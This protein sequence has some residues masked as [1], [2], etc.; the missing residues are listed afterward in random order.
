MSKRDPNAILPSSETSYGLLKG[1]IPLKKLRIEQ[2]DQSPRKQTTAVAAAV[3]PSAGSPC[4]ASQPMASSAPAAYPQKGQPAQ[5]PQQTLPTIPE[6]HEEAD[7]ATTGSRRRCLQ[8]EWPQGGSA[9]AALQAQAQ[10]PEPHLVGR[11][12]Q[13]EVA[14]LQQ[15]LCFDIELA[16]A[17]EEEDEGQEQEQEDV[18]VSRQQE[19]QQQQQQHATANDAAM[20]IDGSQLPQAPACRRRRL[21]PAR[22][23]SWALASPLLAAVPA[24]VLAAVPGLVPAPMQQQQQQQYAAVHDPGHSG[25]ALVPCRAASH[26]MQQPRHLQQ[27]QQQSVPQRPHVQ[28]WPHAQQSHQQDRGQVAATDDPQQHDSDTAMLSA[29]DEATPSSPLA[30]E[31]LPHKAARG[32][33]EHRALI[34][35]RVQSAPELQ[36]SIALNPASL[37]LRMS[38][39]LEPAPL[40][41]SVHAAAPGGTRFGCCGDDSMED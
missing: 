25:W 29:A 2:A 33:L 41:A 23:H 5:T 7:H 15:V 3:S 38:H 32:S 12:Q 31:E 16:M 27:Q 8:L 20:G 14:K 13:V 19:H 35:C 37:T 36:H 30:L 24:S 4:A 18:H 26:P 11:E 1:D 28:Q 22:D 6:A 9:M 17:L 40:A 10:A 21:D 34:D 39:G